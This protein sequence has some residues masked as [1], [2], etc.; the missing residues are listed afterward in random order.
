MT[1]EDVVAALAKAVPE[2]HEYALIGAAARNAWAPPRAST[3]LD[4][5]VAASAAT[6]DRVEAALLPLGYSAS[7]RNRADSSD[8][9]PDI[10]ILRCDEEGL[11]QVDLLV[12]KTRFEQAALQRAVEV[13]APWGGTARVVTAE[14]LI[15]YKL[16][17][18]RD[19][20]RDDVRAVARTQAALGKP[21]DRS[22]VE[23]WAEEWGVTDRLS[24]LD[25]LG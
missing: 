20:D 18:F 23:R 21:I 19:R 6:L 24:L 12:A 17:A 4:F 22:Y 2:D 10:V 15:V 7:R 13:A 5:V 9:L 3:D 1:P 14:D 8:A 16:I 25:D 11:R